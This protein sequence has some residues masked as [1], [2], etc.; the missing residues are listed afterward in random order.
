M[1]PSQSKLWTMTEPKR[2]DFIGSVD[3]L[4]KKEILENLIA[5][6]KSGIIAAIAF[7]NSNKVVQFIF[8]PQ[9]Y[10]DVDGEPSKIVGNASD[11]NEQLMLVEIDIHA[12]CRYFACIWAA[13]RAPDGIAGP[14]KLQKT[15]FA[16]TAWADRDNLS[17]VACVT[18]KIV[19]IFFGYQLQDGPVTCQAVANSFA[20]AGAGYD[21]W[22]SNASAYATTDT[23]D[24]AVVLRNLKAIDQGEETY[25][26][27]ECKD[28]KRTI[29]YDDGLYVNANMVTPD[30]YPTI[31]KKLREFF[32]VTAAVPPTPAVPNVVVK[33]FDDED[34]ETAKSEGLMKLRLF[35][36]GGTLN[37]NGTV[38]KVKLAIF[39]DSMQAVTEGTTGVMIARLG[40]LLKTAFIEMKR[41]TFDLLSQTNMVVFQKSF[42]TL[43]VNGVFSQDQVDTITT[44]KANTL[45]LDAF[46][47]QLDDGRNK[48]A[49]DTEMKLEAEAMMNFAP[50]QRTLAETTIQRLGVINSLQHVKTTSVNLYAAAKSICNMGA[51]QANGGEPLITQMLNKIVGKYR[52]ERTTTW[53]SKV[54]DHCPHH[55]LNVFATNDAIMASVGRFAQDFRNVNMG[56][57][58]KPEEELVLQ[59]LQ[60]AAMIYHEATRSLNTMIALGTPDLQVS[61]LAASFPT[62]SARSTSYGGGGGGGGGGRGGN[63]ATAGANGGGG[64][65]GS[66]G[67]G[68]GR[69]GGGPRRDRS[70]ESNDTSNKKQRGDEEANDDSKQKGFVILKD[71]SMDAKSIFPPNLDRAKKACEDFVCQGR[72]CSFGKNDCPH[73]NH[74][75]RPK[76]WDAK[77][78]DKVADHFQANGHGWFNRTTI[79]RSK[80]F[81]WPK[82]HCTKVLGNRRGPEAISSA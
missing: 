57:A 23:I 19:P 69:G 62:A 34:K 3:N 26:H 68:G 78:L 2:V 46:A 81:W 21:A 33:N 20:E 44:G 70:G 28:G 41:N 35:F 40:N 9:I 15:L 43:L 64:G 29:D 37:D 72:A 24:T 49:R 59:G 50:S 27:A 71:P 55:H 30:R 14:N 5:R 10:Y 60:E 18:T 67:S 75:F 65:K 53:F 74:M 54:R 13:D 25:L 12:S 16:N 52:E 39:S 76:E 66:N 32:G 38:S 79:E 73:G 63:K 31:A 4:F 80:D 8:C 42:L 61:S 11:S 77:E 6:I 58:G 1:A 82:P 47:P 45:S 36:A 51:M 22:I 56:N 48:T 7:V 17:M